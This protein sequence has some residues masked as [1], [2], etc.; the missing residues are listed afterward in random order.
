MTKNRLRRKNNIK[1]AQRNL[2]VRS[3]QRSSY[4]SHRKVRRLFRQWLK[5]NM[6]R[7]KYR[8]YSI[9][10]RHTMF[11]FQGI[12]KHIMLVMDYRRPEAMIFYQSPDDPKYNIDQTI[13]EYIGDE[14]YSPLKGYYDADRTDGVYDYFPTQEILYIHNIFEKIIEFVNEKF[15]SENVL[16]VYEGNWTEAYIV[17]AKELEMK[18]QKMAL[19]ID[20]PKL[21]LLDLFTGE[22][23][24]ETGALIY[25][26]YYSKHK[27]L[28][29][30]LK[31][32]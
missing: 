3:L 18:L 20:N 23:Y 21:Y 4:M 29:E 16:Y 12:E 9:N 28:Y 6:H 2:T 32:N 26:Y 22:K 19:S 15:V 7:F 14:R 8:P 25:K 27:E 30:K 10:R 11:R 31:N 17:T 24:P 5:V 1:Y 13:I